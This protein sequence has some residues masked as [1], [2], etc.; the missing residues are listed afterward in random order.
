MGIIGDLFKGTVV[1]SILA[2]VDHGF[3]ARDM[4]SKAADSH[5]KGLTKYDQYSRMLTG[6]QNSIVLPYKKGYLNGD[7][8]D[9]LTH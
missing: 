8:L 1:L 6:Y 3:A 9:W 7:I 2:L 5:K 4:A